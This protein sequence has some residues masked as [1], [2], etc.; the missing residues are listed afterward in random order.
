M[1]S[2]IFIQE[3]MGRINIRTGEQ[4]IVT[5]DLH[6]LKCANAKRLIKNIIALHTNAF[7]LEIIHGY[8]RGTRLK[9]MIMDNI[10]SDRVKEKIGNPTNNGMTTLIVC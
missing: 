3:E 9:E 5:V 7:V 1:G 4:D 2:F 10:F 8:N 6:G